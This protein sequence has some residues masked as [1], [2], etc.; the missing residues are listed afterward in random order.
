MTSLKIFVSYTSADK[1]WAH[2][3]AWVLREVGHEPFVHEWEVRA[4][5]EHSGLD[6]TP[7]KGS[8]S[9]DWRIL[10]PLH[11]SG[12]FEERTHGCVLERSNREGGFPYPNRGKSSF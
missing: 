7:S 9:S 4:G 1:D 8:R 10:G 12:V 2:W 3:I 5:G 11:R 6:G